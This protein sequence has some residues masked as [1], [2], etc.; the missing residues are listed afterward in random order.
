MLG[1]N[2]EQHYLPPGVH[3]ENKLG[4]FAF[5]DAVRKYLADF[6]CRVC[7]NVLC[8]HG[9]G[10]GSNN[11]TEAQNKTTHAHCPIRKPPVAHA[12]DMLAHM[13]TCSVADTYF[14][15]RMR[16]DLWHHDA[17]LAV[18]HLR[19]FVPYPSC[20]SCT[21]N[22]AHC[23]FA[24]NILIERLLPAAMAMKVVAGEPQHGAHRIVDFKTAMMPV[25]TRCLVMLTYTTLQTMVNN[26]PAVFEAHKQVDSEHIVQNVLNFL[27][28]KT[29][30]GSASWKDQFVRF[31]NVPA[32]LAL[33]DMKLSEWLALTHSFALLVPLT[34]DEDMARYLGRVEDGVPIDSMD[35]KRQG[36][37][38]VV[39]WEKVPEAGIYYCLCADHALRGIC[40]HILLWLVTKGII[41]PPP[42]W[43]AVRVGGPNSKGRDRHYVDG[44]ALLRD[45]QPSLHARAKVAK[46]LQDPR[47]RQDTRMALVACKGTICLENDSIRKY[48]GK[49]YKYGM[50]KPRRQGG[51]PKA[52][53][54]K[55][56]KRKPVT[57]TCDLSDNDDHGASS[58]SSTKAPAARGGTKAGNKRKGPRNKTASSRKRKTFIDDSEQVSSAVDS[59]R[60]MPASKRGKR[61]DRT[62]KRARLLPGEHAAASVAKYLAILSITEMPRKKQRELLEVVLMTESDAA[63]KAMIEDSL[64]DDMDLQELAGILEEAECICSEGDI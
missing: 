5:R 47:V 64:A 16:R 15:A 40:L 60:T 8:P 48:A 14:D 26:H 25:R 29:E 2:E 58:C 45:Q 13:H 32:S 46:G 35:S 31:F 37:G 17:F 63:L 42:K 28:S 36:N 23:V 22:V 11:A 49:D 7:A 19:N 3:F 38:C 53:A 50:Q 56:Q 52:Q 12:L 54:Q 21:F 51:A 55:R 61:K 44:S 20:P 1:E 9:G 33:E 34:D 27:S 41:T 24:E 4:E 59:P 6:T 62:G 18:D 57:E 39:N 43:S 30:N 10:A